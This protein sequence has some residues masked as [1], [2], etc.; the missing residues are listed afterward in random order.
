MQRKHR[1]AVLSSAV[2]A[3]FVLLPG[4]AAARFPAYIWLLSSSGPL[5]Q[6]YLWLFLS[7]APLLHY[8]APHCQDNFSAFLS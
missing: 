7:P 3:V 4:D 1:H 5:Q 8:N 2:V 6:V